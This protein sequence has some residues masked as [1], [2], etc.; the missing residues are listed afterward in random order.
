MIRVIGEN[1]YYE[2]LPVG[3]LNVKEIPP[4]ELARIIN[5]IEYKWR[6]RKYSKHEEDE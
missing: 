3:K 6:Q 2:S 1:I 4:T 5:D